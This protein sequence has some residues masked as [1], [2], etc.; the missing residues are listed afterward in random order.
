MNQKENKRIDFSKGPHRQMLIWQ[1]RR[2]WSDEEVERNAKW[3]DMA[4]GMSVVDVGCGLG[5][6]GYTYWKYFGQNGFYVG[7][8]I[9]L[10]LLKDAKKISQ[11]WTKGGKSVFINGDSYS[12]PINDNFADL[13]MGQT[14]MIHLEKP[15][16]ALA[17]MYRVLKPGGKILCL[18]PDNFRTTLAP[19]FTSLPEFDIDELL[20]FYKIKHISRR[21]RIK[22]GRGDEGIAPSI[23]H[24][25]NDIGFD[26]IEVR[27]KETV[28][29]LD[30]P[31][32]TETQKERI[33]NLKKYWLNK[34]NFDERIKESKEEFL[35]GGGDISDFEKSLKI[36]KN[37][38]AMQLQQM[39]NDEFYICGVYP[40]Y[41]IKA[42]KPL[43]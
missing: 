22:M 18:E 43:E 19:T 5:Y 14:L 7:V 3:V 30:P 8:D 21:G 40:F 42:V 12:L 34:E 20:L 41:I 36:G 15:K 9:S 25:L 33:G 26:N 38:R 10:S 16:D 37:R 4:P 13:I 11:D 23:P 2:W 31:Y 27:A 6:L 29:Y 32:K 35:A 1:R 39:E 17:E 24:F 28:S